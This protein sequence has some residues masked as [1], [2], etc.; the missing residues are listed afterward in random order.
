MLLGLEVLKELIDGRCGNRRA[1]LF[2]RGG[3]TTLCKGYGV[4][5]LVGGG[6]CWDVLERD[7]EVQS[8][9]NKLARP[10]ETKAT[11]VR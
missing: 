4:S 9:T 5:T 1:V 8:F 10:G 6:E 3:S 11:T 2:L 7:K